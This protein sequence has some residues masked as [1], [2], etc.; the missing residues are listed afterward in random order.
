MRSTRATG[1]STASRKAEA[2]TGGGSAGAGAAATAADTAAVG[3]AVAGTVA[4][5]GAVAGPVAVG[6]A[7]ADPAAAGGTVAGRP[8]CGPALASTTRRSVVAAESPC[9]GDSASPA[10]GGWVDLPGWARTAAAEPGGSVRGTASGLPQSPQKRASFWTLA[11][12]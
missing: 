5:G 7:A 1:D 9:P 4:V 12:Q 10:D 6:G 3:G 2:R 11:P 8:G